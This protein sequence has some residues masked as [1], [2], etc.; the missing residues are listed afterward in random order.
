MKYLGIDYGEK[1]VGL[2]ISDD[3]GQ[4]SFS[5]KVLKNNNE[6][7]D[8]IHNICGEEEIKEI[9]LGEPEDRNKIYEKVLNF[10]KKLKEELKLPV[11]KEKEFMTSSY[12]GIQKSKDMF[13]DRKI[14]KDK[15]VKDDSK[16]AT[17]IL[18]RFLDK[19]NNKNI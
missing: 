6:L 3:G 15:E 5:Y 10:E 4:F 1:R 17:F 18:Q 8:S 14:K 9:V 2:A 7:I 13:I 16:A 12:S 19:I 11:Y